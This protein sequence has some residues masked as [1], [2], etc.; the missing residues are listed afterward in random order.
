MVDEGSVKMSG[1]DQQKN[2]PQGKIKR[3]NKCV[4]IILKTELRGEGASV[5]KKTEIRQ[6]TYTENTE[7]RATVRVLSARLQ[8]GFTFTRRLTA[9]CHCKVNKSV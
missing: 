3:N 2:K 5:T 7:V 4:T 9:G 8:E 6:R 1:S